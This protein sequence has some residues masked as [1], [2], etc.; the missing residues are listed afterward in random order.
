MRTF[1]GL[2]SRL[3]AEFETVPDVLLAAKRQGIDHHGGHRKPRDADKKIILRRRRKSAM[4][5]SQRHCGQQAEGVEVAGVIGH[6]HKRTVLGQI[7]AARD[8]KAMV[9]LEPTPQDS[10]TTERNP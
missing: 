2:A 1:P 9:K 4:Q 10:A 8:F 6:Y 5:F 3:P 7:F